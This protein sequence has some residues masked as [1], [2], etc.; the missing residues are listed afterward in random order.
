MRSFFFKQVF[1]NLE[2]CNAFFWLVH[3]EKENTDET[4][5]DIRNYYIS[6][7]EDFKA[8]LEEYD[9]WNANIWSQI[10]FRERGL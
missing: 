10:D 4:E 8:K 3:L 9:E 2:I 7:F 5:N 6:L 1:K